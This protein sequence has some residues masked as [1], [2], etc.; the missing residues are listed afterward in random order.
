MLRPPLHFWRQG[1]LSACSACDGHTST[2]SA[3]GPK[4]TSLA[5]PHTS[6]FGGKA[7]MGYCG[8]P[9]SWSLLQQLTESLFTARR[10]ARLCEPLISMPQGRHDQILREEFRCIFGPPRLHLLRGPVAAVFSRV[11]FPPRPRWKIC[12]LTAQ[13][14]VRQPR[15]P[16]RVLLLVR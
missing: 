15:K 3:I 11:S 5:A 6:A 1:A 4:R 9:L 7:D 16:E 12:K 10:M 2:M 14:V 13:T 8:S